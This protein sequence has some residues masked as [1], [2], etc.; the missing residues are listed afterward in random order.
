MQTALAKVTPYQIKMLHALS[1]ALGLTKDE[2]RSRIAEMHG[3]SGSCLDLNSIEADHLIS[4]WRAEAI[5][6][7]V[8]KSHRPQGT[9]QSKL[10]KYD[11]LGRRK[12]M[13]TPKQL[14]MIEAMWA[15]VS[16]AQ[17]AIARERALKGLLK[18]IIKVDDMRF[19]EMWHVKVLIK[20]LESMKEAK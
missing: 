12:G 5:E 16:R 8:W 9:G 11:D 15:G 20:A 1:N 6:A 10:L 3:F 2:Y 13:A 14:R 7:G 19:V 4:N 18:R 17:G